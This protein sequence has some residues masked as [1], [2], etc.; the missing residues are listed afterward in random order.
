MRH[1]CDASVLTKAFV[2]EEGSQAVTELLLQPGEWT[3]SHLG[4]VEGASALC[5]AA[6][7]G[8]LPEDG[9]SVVAEAI[10]KGELAPLQVQPI[11]AE[12]F[13]TAV[14]LVC[15]RPLRAGDA[16][17]LASASLAK[18]EVFIC[19]DKRLLLAAEREGLTCIGPA[20]EAAEDE[21]AR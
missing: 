13:A 8:R 4:L 6:R 14:S 5:R 17:H 1:Y 10:R 7:E 2:G 18:A 9:V 11:S 15:R 21:F 3:T 20:T 16:L 19:S 12:T